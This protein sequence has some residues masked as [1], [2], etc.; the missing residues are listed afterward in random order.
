[1][2][3]GRVP[4]CILNHVKKSI[5]RGGLLMG[6]SRCLGL[7]SRLNQEVFCHMRLLPTLLMM[8]LLTASGAVVAQ[9]YMLPEGP[10]KAEIIHSCETCHGVQAVIVHKRSPKQWDETLKTMRGFGASLTDAQAQLILA[11][12]NKNVGQPTDFVPYPM[13]LRGKG[14][15]IQLATEAAI[16]AQEA[17]RAQ[18]HE[19]ALVVVDSGGTPV[20][21]LLGDGV[22]PLLSLIVLHKTNA[23]LKFKES[24]GE[25]MKRLEKDPVLAAQLKNDP[26]I[27]EVRQ[28]GLPLV[29][30]NELVGA[31]AISGAFGPADTDEKCVRVGVD[32]IAARL[33]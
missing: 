19:V 24:S 14:P 28:G 26:Q 21:S 31:M 20:V 7:Q 11:Y 9:D 30:G 25:V 8:G 29:A 23:V 13:P 27:G 3:S 4:F 17:C 22:P 12:L 2:S 33:K 15:G 6:F 16:A 32:K 18:G 1:M 10:G 5:D